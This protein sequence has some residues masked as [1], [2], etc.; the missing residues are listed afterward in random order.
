MSKRLVEEN[1]IPTT[2]QRTESF[3]QSI[4]Y[5]LSAGGQFFNVGLQQTRS[6]VIEDFRKKSTREKP[7]KE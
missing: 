7:L 1:G 5:L 6:G 2:Q 3:F 4:P